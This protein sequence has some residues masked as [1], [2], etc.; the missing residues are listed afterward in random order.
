LLIESATL[1]LF[2]E[3]IPSTSNPINAKQQ[4]EAIFEAQKDLY[5]LS[6]GRE[7]TTLY[8]KPSTAVNP[9][10]M[11]QIYESILYSGKG[12]DESNFLAQYSRRERK[13]SLKKLY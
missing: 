10:W 6:N 8:L 7:A 9:Q 3:L 12:S 11:Q 5:N 4:F 2:E 1:S 13:T